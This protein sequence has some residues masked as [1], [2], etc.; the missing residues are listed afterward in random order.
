M[1]FEGFVQYLCKNGHNWDNDV[2]WDDDSEKC[3]ICEAEIV[4]SNLVDTTNGSFCNCNEGCEN[5]EDG[6][7]DGYIELEVKEPAV[8]SECKECGTKKLI[9][10]ETYK[11][12]LNNS[13]A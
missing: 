8:Y 11:V 7:I 6:R 10:E 1:S 12:P 2:Y 9:K 4:W 3:P 5:C 13:R